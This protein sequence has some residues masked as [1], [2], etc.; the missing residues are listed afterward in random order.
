MLIRLK[1]GNDAASVHGIL[2]AE[3]TEAAIDAQQ[4]RDEA[5]ARC[6]A[7]LEQARVECQAL[8]ASGQQQALDTLRQAQVQAQKMA[9]MAQKSIQDAM[10]RAY[11][12]GERQAAAQWHERHA[13]QVSRHAQLM[14]SMNE[15]L[16]GVVCA[17]V[18]RIVSAEPRSALFER[19]LKQVQSLTR[20]AG[21]LWVRVHPDDLETACAALSRLM[22]QSNV[23][24]E[25]TADAALS[26]GG[27]IFE[28]E[29][30]VLDASLDVQLAAM[31]QAL[32]RVAH[33]P[34]PEVEADADAAAQ[35]GGDGQQVE[36]HEAAHAQVHDDPYGDPDPDH[37]ED[38]DGDHD[39]PGDDPDADLDAAHEEDP[40]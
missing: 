35:D 27:C 12:A 14:E 3:E 34:E 31:R 20:G 17:A 15:R 1:A 13:E 9:E 37:D 26:P 25:V 2:R 40:Q 19:A 18:E 36:D 5:R 4:L 7:M 22:Q 33:L 21:S 16:A 23:Q 24:V 8:V 29:M 28:S 30:G 11:Q 32:E 39:D 38:H 10:L 6:T